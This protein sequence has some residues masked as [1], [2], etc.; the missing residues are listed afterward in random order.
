M[1]YTKLWKIIH[2]FLALV[3]ALVVFVAEVA[4][5]DEKWIEPNLLITGIVRPIAVV[6]L[7]WG[8]SSHGIDSPVLLPWQGRASSCFSAS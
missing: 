7:F 4:V 8:H 3:T 6:L 5:E 2:G 1:P